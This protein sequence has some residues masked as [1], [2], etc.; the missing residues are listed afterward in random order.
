MNRSAAAV[1]L[2]GLLR[3][4]PHTPHPHTHDAPISPPL[5]RLV[6]CVSTVGLVA[7]GVFGCA[8]AKLSLWVCGV[9]E[10]SLGVKGERFG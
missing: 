8:L 7:V 3:K 9:F 2:D 5:Q 4:A 6:R 10:L 1:R